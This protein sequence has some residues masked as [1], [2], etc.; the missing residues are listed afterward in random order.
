MADI[1]ISY[2]SQD[3]ERA[4]ELSAE[5]RA[6]GISVWV[7]KQSIDGAAQWS[8]E[9]ARAVADCKA[10]LLLISKNSMASKNCAKEVTIAAEAD[11]H[12]LPVNLENI[13]LPVEFKYHLAGLH[14]VAYS[15]KDAVWRAIENLVSSKPI[16]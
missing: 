1:F 9:I 14:R 15:N 5:L 12:I 13:P 16:E 10:L 4:L 7:D 2:S 3:S 6:R 8:S 11:K